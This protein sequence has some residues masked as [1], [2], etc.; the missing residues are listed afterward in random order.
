MTELI[1]FLCAFILGGAVGIVFGVA[2]ALA[3]QGVADKGLTTQE[4][5]SIR[6]SEAT[7]YQRL[8][9]QGGDFA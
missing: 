9:W 5:K 1:D 7:D 3:A 6:K 2:L 4:D 8:A